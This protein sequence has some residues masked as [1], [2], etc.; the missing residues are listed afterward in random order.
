MYLARHGETDWN[1]EQRVQGSTCKPLN[2]NGIAQATAL[3]E[4]LADAPLDHIVTSPLRRAALTA[5]IV[6][7]HHPSNP[8]LVAEPRLAEMCF[9]D[10]EGR[11]LPDFADTYRET[12]DAWARGELDVRWPGEGGESCEDVAERAL[13][14][15][16]SI[17]GSRHVLVVAHS[18]V[19]KSL[20]A[21]LRGDLSRCSDVQQG[22]TCLNI[23]DLAPQ[24]L[25]EDGSVSTILL[26]FRE[27]VERSEAWS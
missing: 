27:H 14:A 24:A 6:R 9:G 3:A 13:A 11:R 17:S 21:L 16:K 5:E 1:L 7:D 10:I 20:I 23:F 2:A 22:N 4:L 25:D 12:L 15:L 8:T 18:R 26:D 19:N